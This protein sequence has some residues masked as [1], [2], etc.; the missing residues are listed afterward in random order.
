MFDVIHHYS[1]KK[2]LRS[3]RKIL[4]VKKSW[5]KAKGFLN[6]WLFSILDKIS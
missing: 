3:V 2:P 1:S 5:L 4:S 6:G